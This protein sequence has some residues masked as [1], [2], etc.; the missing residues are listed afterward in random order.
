[1]PTLGVELVPTELKVAAIQMDCVLQHVSENL[2]HTQG[3]LQQAAEQGVHLAVLPDLFSTGFALGFSGYKNFLS[4]ITLWIASAPIAAF[5]FNAFVTKEK[6]DL[7]IIA[8][9]LL[10]IIGTISVVGHKEISAW[11]T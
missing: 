5:I 4:I 3:L 9:L 10:V 6:V 11:L 2:N 1:M 8:G 7:P